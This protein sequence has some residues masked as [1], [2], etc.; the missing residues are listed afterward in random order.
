M[1]RCEIVM[2]PRAGTGLR[3]AIT[4]GAVRALCGINTENWYLEVR[5]PFDAKTIGCKRCKAAWIKSAHKRGAD[6]G[7]G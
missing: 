5:H 7:K 4:L 6:N 2:P 1:M 3:H